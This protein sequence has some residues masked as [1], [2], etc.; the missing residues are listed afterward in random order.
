MMPCR[1]MR[2]PR[3]E[4]RQPFLGLPSAPAMSEALAIGRDIMLARESGA[5][6]HFRQ[7]TTAAGLDLIRNAKEEGLPVSCGITPSHLF[8]SDQAIADFRTFCRL[9]PPLRDEADRLACIAAIGDGTIDVIAS[10]HDPRGPEDK[11]LP[12]AEAAPGSTGA[13]TLLALALNLVREGHISL[14]RLFDLLARNPAQLLGV[15]AGAVSAG[16]EADLILIN[17]GRTMADKQ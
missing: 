11:R 16:Y 7:V 15:E 4:R 13:Q 14:G 5:R 3:R 10:G 12:F 1:A 8:L 9:S 2:L 17:L 6:V